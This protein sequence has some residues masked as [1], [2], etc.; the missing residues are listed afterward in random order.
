MTF[1]NDKE[2]M[3]IQLNKL[4]QDNFNMITDNIKDIK[5]AKNSTDLI[6]VLIKANIE[7]EDVRKNYLKKNE[8]RI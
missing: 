7:I 2:N 6:K 3:I 4:R 5:E 1:E 8:E